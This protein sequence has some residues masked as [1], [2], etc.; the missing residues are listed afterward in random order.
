MASYQTPESKKQVSIAHAI[1]F[2]A[3]IGELSGLCAR[4]GAELNSKFLRLLL[5]TCINLCP[6]CYFYRN[7]ESIWRRVV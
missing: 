4:L 1:L 7:F 6:L 3:P 2:R 5:A